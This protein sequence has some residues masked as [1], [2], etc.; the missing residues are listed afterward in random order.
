MPLS[1]LSLLLGAF[2]ILAL[3]YAWAT[4]IFEAS[5]ELWHFGVV[6]HIANTG[7]LPVQ[8]IGVETP[9]EQEGSQPPLYYLIAAA[10]VAPID[11]SDFEA[12]RQ[13]NPHA[14][15]GVPGAVGNKNLVQHDMTHPP[16]QD[17]TLAV[18]VARV[19]SIM[20]GFVTV[21]AVYQ[22]ACIAANDNRN[23]ALLAAGLTAFNPMFLFIAASVNNDNLVT[24]L[25][26]LIIW[27]M[28]VM[29]SAGFETRRGLILAILLGLSAISKLSGLVLIPAVALAAL[30]VA[31]RTRNWRGM[32]ALGAMIGLAWVLVA[33]WWYA[34]NLWLYGEVFGTRTMAEVAGVR[35]GAFTLQ[36]LLSEFQGFR[37]GY[38]GVFGAFNIMTF[39]W[40]YDVMDI[41]TLLGI[42]GLAIYVWR[43]RTEREH[44]IPIALLAIVIAAGDVGV[45]AW[46]AQTYASQG[47]LL[48]PYI[49]AISSLL[50]IG[51]ANLTPLP[52]LH[53]PG[54]ARN[55]VLPSLIAIFA[56]FALIVP[57]ASIAPQ[58]DPPPPLAALPDTARPVYARYGDIALIGYEVLEQRYQPG[59]IVP[60]TL[61]WQVVEQSPRDLSLFL[62][63][64]TSDG[65]V[66][67]K[68]DSYPGAGRLR[69][70]TW[71]VEAIYS[72]SYGIPLDLDAEG[73][74]A[75]RIQVGWWH[76][77]SEELIAV[78]SEDGQ[79]LD[80]VL[81]DA[82]AFVGNVEITSAADNLIETEHVE[83]SESIRL[84]GYQLEGNILTLGWE[85]LGSPESDYTVFAQVVDESNIIVGQGDA[86][87]ELPTRYWR[88]G[89]RYITTHSITYPEPPAPGTYRILIG[90]YRPDNFERLTAPFPDNAYPLTS[91]TVE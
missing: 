22:T 77:P 30:W 46:T 73:R 57:V 33:G 51:L 37:F 76:Y 4:P 5:D 54:R 55:A 89:E 19:F 52:S 61:Y 79:S 62:N 3:I 85:A 41:V 90:W 59:D 7:E 38:W 28:L 21:Y 91:I 72:D 58:Y 32:L 43:N 60:I 71:Q 81:P 35:E 6:N 18:Y 9:W 14:I 44:V 87:P 36:T 40:Y 26:S 80:S 29:M 48:F 39:R 82:G 42:I 50:A 11:R 45:I 86:P 1:P 83:F 49:A 75:L 8:V 70:T 47:R 10:L 63:A 64:V 25:N 68:V 15:A 53:V 74:S 78:T 16:L 13:P 27:E 23:I 67:G 2:I 56:L 88:A 20:L 31:Q 69:T 65:A 24:A 12:I 66:I 34:R 84:T 17:T